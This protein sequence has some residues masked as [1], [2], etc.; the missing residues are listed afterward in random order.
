MQDDTY[1]VPCDAFTSPKKP[2]QEIQKEE[3][4]VRS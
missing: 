3:T 1:Y 2:M 4:F